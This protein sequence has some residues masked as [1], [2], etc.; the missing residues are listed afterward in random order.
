[1]SRIMLDAGHGGTDPGAVGNGLQE[2][3]TNLSIILKIN[4]I[5]KNEYENVETN[6]TRETDVFLSL[7]ERTSKANDWK[8][9]CFVSVH[10]NASTN[11]SVRGFETYIYPITDDRTKTFQNVM[12]REIIKQIP[13]VRDIGQKTANFHVLRETNM[14]AILTENLF[15]S[16]SA[17]A[18]L[19]KDDSFLN[20]I[21]RGHVNGLAAFFGLT[22]KASP[23]P[24]T[25][26]LYQVI[27]GTFENKENAEKRVQ[28]LK[29]SGYES[30]INVKE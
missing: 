21:A 24:S 12:H 29:A 23:P 26:V 14:V 30:Y 10:S 1:M 19:L 15:I 25:R 20:K 22:R 4:A 7:G 11:N 13:D 8:A 28:D 5:L 3:E 18:A 2:K 9:D 16:N 17:D 6:L 27:T